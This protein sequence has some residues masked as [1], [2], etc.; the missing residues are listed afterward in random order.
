MD[1]GSFC[2]SLA[3]RLVHHN[4]WNID[5]Q[6]G[7]FICVQNTMD[8]AIKGA[9]TSHG[10]CISYVYW[11]CIS[12][13]NSSHTFHHQFIHNRVDP[14]NMKLDYQGSLIA[15]INFDPF[16]WFFKTD[17]GMCVVD[18]VKHNRLYVQANF[19]FKIGF[20][21]WPIATYFQVDC[22]CLLNLSAI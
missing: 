3:L 1:G 2:Y 17:F 20:R 14:I 15:R 19:Y 22:N 8:V 11:D 4:Q 9:P 16:R 10:L 5:A 6:N 21:T 13:I 12:W 18:C 7:T